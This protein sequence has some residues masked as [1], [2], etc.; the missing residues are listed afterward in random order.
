[1]QDGV[2]IHALETEEHG[3]EIEKDLKEVNGKKYA[4]YIGNN[5]SL[6]HQ[7]QVHGPAVVL[8]NTF[9]GM[10]ALVFNATVGQNC[11][12]EPA[13]KIIGVDIPDHK[14]VKAGSIITSPEQVKA[15]QNIDANY[16]FKDLNKAVVHVNTE[17][18]ETYNKLYGY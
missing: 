17:L 8:D 3:Q 1:M 5:V 18:A 9:I 4:V 12:I 14:Y 10:Q 16:K 13:A 7:S 15:L 6:A 2:V 11:V